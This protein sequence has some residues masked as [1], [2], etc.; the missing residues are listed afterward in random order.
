MGPSNLFIEKNV[1]DK[2]DNG[3]TIK[4]VTAAMLSNFSAQRPA[5]KPSAASKQEPRIPKLSHK[6]YVQMEF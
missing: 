3:T 6:K 4:F 1:P 2:N 5:I